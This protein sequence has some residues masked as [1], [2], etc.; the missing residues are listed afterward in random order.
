MLVFDEITKKRIDSSKCKK[1]VVSYDYSSVKYGY[2]S[3]P[4]EITT[5]YLK[6]NGE[7]KK[8]PIYYEKIK[9]KIFFSNKQGLF[10]SNDVDKNTYIT[11]TC[12][13]GRN[14]FPYTFS[15][16]YEA[17]ESFSI[18]KDKQKVIDEKSFPLSNHL[19]YTFGLE[20]ETSE[21]IVPEMF[22]FRDGLIPLR[23][24]S[25]SGIEYSTVVLEGNKGLNLLRQQINTLREYTIFNKECSLHIHFGGFPLD[26]EKIFRLYSLCYLLQL[27]QNLTPYLPP[28]TFKTSQY[29]A[30]GK[31]YCRVLP[32]YRNFENMYTSLV[33]QP[34]LGSFTQPHPNDIDRQRKWNIPTR[35][36][37]INFINFLC[38]D[39]NKTIEFR[40]LR[41]SYNL[42]KILVWLYILNAI[43]I[44]AENTN[45]RIPDIDDPDFRFANGYLLHFILDQVYPKE[46]S[47]YLK[48]EL[49]KL[50]LLVQS[51]T[52]N[53]NDR[54]GEMINLENRLFPQDEI[55]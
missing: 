49:Y 33:G 11:E 15:R 5:A 28:L 9:D 8:F 53:N 13:L 12:I 14:I 23:D 55:I 20:F 38:Y 25:I 34:F 2:V 10:I 41:P 6:H 22:C 45:L 51:Q 21:G 32:V 31:D 35:Y 4:T 7:T 29:K 42:K 37:W 50:R 16:Y 18:F 26:K 27:N 52:R 43:L 46:L 47:E 3:D 30:S 19:K 39:V 36:Y 1:V 17:I 44:Y 40:F 24:G 48:S 54:I